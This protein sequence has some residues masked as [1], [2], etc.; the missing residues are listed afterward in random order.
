MSSLIKKSISTF[1]LL[2]NHRN[3]DVF[4]DKMVGACSVLYFIC[5]YNAGTM[6]PFL[7]TK[8]TVVQ[9]FKALD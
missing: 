6:Q 2:W 9:A 4:E 5:F 3:K 1:Q 7:A 8:E